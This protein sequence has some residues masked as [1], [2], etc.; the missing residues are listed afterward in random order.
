MPTARTTVTLKRTVEGLVVTSV[1][2]NVILIQ[3]DY[4]T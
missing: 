2:P 3:Y 1:E 4:A